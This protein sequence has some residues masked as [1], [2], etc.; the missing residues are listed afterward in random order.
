MLNQMLDV[1]GIFN[2]YDSFVSHYLP[3]DLLIQY[4]KITSVLAIL[5]H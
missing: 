3:R 4:F 2:E 5:S 1:K